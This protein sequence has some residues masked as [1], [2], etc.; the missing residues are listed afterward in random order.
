MRKKQVLR[1]FLLKINRINEVNVKIYEMFTDT[2]LY[3]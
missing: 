2:I 1:I 3:L